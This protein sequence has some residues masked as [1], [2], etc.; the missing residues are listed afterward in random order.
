MSDHD[1]SGVVE[2]LTAESERGRAALREVMAHSYETD[3]EGVPP[4]WARTL[5]VDGVPVSFIIVDPNR[6]MDQPGE[7]LRYVFI[8]DVATRQ[9]RRGEGRFRQ[10]MT[11]TF[12]D[13]RAAGVPLVATHGRYP[14]Y[15]RFGFDVFTHHCGLFATPE[16]IQRSLGT[17]TEP[18]AERHLVVEAFAGLHPDL[19]LVT[20]VRSQS[21]AEHRAALQAAAALACARGKRRILFEHPA[22]PSYG[23]RY[24]IHPTLVTPF[25]ALALTCGATLHVQGA[26]P[27][28][29]PVPDADWLKVLDTASLLRDALRGPTLHVPRL[30]LA[31]GF[32]TD[33]GDA[34]IE[35][36]ET[37]VVVISR[38]DEPV[39]RVPWPSAA[40]AQLVT[41]YRDARMLDSVH[42]AGLPDWALD[43]LDAAFPRRWRLSRNEGWV[44]AV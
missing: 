36:A 16:G 22:A 34:T 40:L 32:S 26:D 21:P 38:L 8:R 18:G 35:P 11:H 14:L 30:P 29:S 17:S 27:E 33:A 31:L 24:P 43:W 7:A 20:E 12:R 19:L 42:G 39:L 28:N 25:T 2:V 37:G 15:R 3:S 4:A 5:L 44:F 1:R 9:D 41:G 23:S 6:C 10:I 13:L